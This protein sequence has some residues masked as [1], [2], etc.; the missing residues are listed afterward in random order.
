[1]HVEPPFGTPKTRTVWLVTTVHK[2]HSAHSASSG[3]SY[4]GLNLVMHSTI[5]PHFPLPGPAPRL[6]D[7][8]APGLNDLRHRVDGGTPAVDSP[9]HMAMASMWPVADRQYWPVLPDAEE[10]ILAGD[11]LVT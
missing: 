2:E 10:D 4:A 7:G 8:R 6:F 5:S 3:G 9:A 1:M 11:M